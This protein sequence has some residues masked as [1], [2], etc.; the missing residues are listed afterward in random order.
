MDL[1]E[2]FN[3]NVNKKTALINIQIIDWYDEPILGFAKVRNVNQWM[4]FYLVSWDIKTNDKVFV[5]IPVDL[6]L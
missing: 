1:I 4:F 5:L 2:L 3:K 6:D